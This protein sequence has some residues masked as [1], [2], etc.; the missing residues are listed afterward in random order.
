LFAL[1]AVALV[2]V[3][4]AFVLPP[5]LRAR[6]Q[7]RDA[8][9]AAVRDAIYRQG[10]DELQQ[11]V[12]HDEL[13]RD[14][15]ERARAELHRR[16]VEDSSGDA[17]PPPKAGRRRA[18]AVVGIALPLVAAALYLAVGKPDA[19]TDDSVAPEQ[20][21]G[22]ADYIARLQAHLKRQPRDTR[23]WVLL[24]RAHAGRDDFGAAAAA[25]ERALDVPGSKAAKDP[26]VLVEYAD[27][28]GMNQGGR[29]DGK[30]GELIERALA[31]DPSHPVAL[32][33]AGSAAY[34]AG[35]YADSVRYWSRLLE[36]L[37]P[38]SDRHQELSAAIARAQR[39]A[40][41]SLPR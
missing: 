40:A 7:R 38:D 23:G 36:Q 34:G 21:A 31:I 26:A 39:R 35:R 32:E 29:L 12:E 13:P 22:D 3:A 1:V 19:L 14:E 37:P 18:A 24:A 4:L 33:M 30:P 41:V 11:E 28:L 17:A 10:V 6:V 5:L 25:Y 2:G 16:L 27:A 15:A 20:G 9:R 8:A